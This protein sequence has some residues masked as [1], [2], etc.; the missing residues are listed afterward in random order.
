MNEIQLGMDL[1]KIIANQKAYKHNLDADNL[2]SFLLEKFCSKILPKLIS[3][4]QTNKYKPKAF[5]IKSLNGYALNFLRDH[6]RPIKI[7]RKYKDLYMQE[8]AMLKRQPNSTDAQIAMECGTDLESLQIMRKLMHTKF[9]SF[10][11][12]LN[13]PI[14]EQSTMESLELIDYADMY[15]YLCELSDKDFKMAYEYFVM[16]NKKLKDEPIN[17]KLIRLRNQKNT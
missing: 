15:N 11:A 8:R 3:A 12:M 9:V 17:N 13:E 6:S 5:I 2:Y 4:K 10:D 7:S 14:T 16:N 1:A